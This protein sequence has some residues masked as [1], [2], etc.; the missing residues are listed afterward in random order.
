MNTVWSQ[1]VQGINTLY[2]TRKLRFDDVFSDQ[3]RRLFALDEKQ[4]QKHD[5]GA[6]YG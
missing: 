2:Y 4:T 6:C 1:Y 3:Y 5:A